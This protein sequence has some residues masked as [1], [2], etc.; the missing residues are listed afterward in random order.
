MATS[1]TRAVKTL[2]LS[3]DDLGETIKR[4]CQAREAAAAACQPLD[5]ARDQ[6]EHAQQ[7]VRIA[8]DKLLEFDRA[9]AQAAGQAWPPQSP[10]TKQREQRRALAEDLSAAERTLPVVEAKAEAARGPAE[11]AAAKVAEIE[12]EIDVKIMAVM[13]EEGQAALARLI[14]AR[15]EAV[16][17]EAAV[18]SIAAAMVD[19]GWLSAAEKISTALFTMRR[20]EGSVNTAPYLRFIERLKSDPDATVEV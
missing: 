1:P 10:S 3:R 12:R 14:G 8:D 11:Q 2:S 16:A 20:P 4:L 18:R 19:R 5:R 9:Q 6:Q 17:A 7:L 15:R 13:A